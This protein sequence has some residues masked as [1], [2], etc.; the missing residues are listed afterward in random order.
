MRSIALSALLLGCL[1]CAGQAR[2]D[3]E[4]EISAALDYFAEVWQEG[5]L[6]TMRGY[7]HPDFVLVTAEGP[8]SLT[9]R[10]ADLDAI[11]KSGEDRGELNHSGVKIQALSDAH[12][13][14][15][16]KRRLAFRDGSSIETWFSTVY[17]KTPFGWKA[18]LTHQ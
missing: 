15:W 10:M 7:Y 8:V 13:L 9:Q 14:A 4:A 12:A 17:A 1:C 18:I 5:D 16:G 11:T 6:E 2:A 3:T